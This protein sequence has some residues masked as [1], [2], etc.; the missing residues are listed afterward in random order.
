ML[1]DRGQLL[2]DHLLD[3]L[4]DLRAGLAH[5][6]DPQRDVRLLALGQAGEHLR[7]ER[8]VQAGEDQRD[9]LGRLAA[10]ERGGALGRDALQELERR[11]LGAGREPAEQLG[12]AL[13][14]ERALDHLARE[15][16]ATGQR[17]VSGSASAASSP[18]IESVVSAPD[19]VEARHLHRQALDLVLAQ[20]L[21]HVG[22]ALGAERRHQHGRLARAG[23]VLDRSRAGD[24]SGAAGS[25][26]RVS[27]EALPGHPG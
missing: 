25:A 11:R 8:R 10:Q 14:A 4:D 19:R 6:G 3:L 15:V 1:D 7:G 26:G 27:V 16:H 5:A 13:G 18:K 20:P 9:R 12:G 24:R 21:Q 2:A 23:E 17:R 22:R